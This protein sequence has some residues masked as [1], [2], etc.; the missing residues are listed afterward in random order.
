M[1]DHGWAR[2]CRILLRVGF[3]SAWPVARTAPRTRLLIARRGDTAR[4]TLREAERGGWPRRPECIERTRE[5]CTPASSAPRAGGRRARWVSCEL[6]RP[7]PSGAIVERRWRCRFGQA[8]GALRRCRVRATELAA[9][10]LAGLATVV[11]ADVYLGLPLGAPMPR[12]RADGANQ[13]R[14][15]H[16]R[17]HVL[18]RLCRHTARQLSCATGRSESVVG[19]Q[20]TSVICLPAVETTGPSHPP[21][22]AEWGIALEFVGCH[23]ALHLNLA[24]CV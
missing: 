2:T 10:L 14:T 20:G 11:G 23:S 9:W 1:L 24:T 13:V 7:P 17:A 3:Q 18:D 21:H 15:K 8:A 12:S 5:P 4:S 22:V 16:R 19:L 6:R